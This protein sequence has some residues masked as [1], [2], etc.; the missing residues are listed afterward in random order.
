MT[1]RH[2][3]HETV[4]MSTLDFS[5]HFGTGYQP[6]KLFGQCARCFNSVDPQLQWL[7]LLSIAH[8]NMSCIKLGCTNTIAYGTLWII[9]FVS[10]TTIDSMYTFFTALKSNLLTKYVLS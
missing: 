6:E 2:I 4:D 1:C 10:L 8:F 9:N 7:P 5:E 3:C